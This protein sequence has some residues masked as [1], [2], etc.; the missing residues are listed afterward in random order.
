MLSKIAPSSETASSAAPLLVPSAQLVS[1]SEAPS[2]KRHAEPTKSRLPADSAD[3]LELT[4]MVGASPLAVPV[5][6]RG[7]SE[8]LR[9]MLS[10]HISLPLML[11]FRIS[12]P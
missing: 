8:L 3:A 2:V 4:K 1:P 12:T 6:T 5:T 10:Q 11:L 7:L 9:F